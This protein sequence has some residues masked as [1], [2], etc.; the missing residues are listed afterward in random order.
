MGPNFTPPTD[1]RVG[2]A[3]DEE[4]C[5]ESIAYCLQAQAGPVS[6]PEVNPLTRTREMLC[7]LHQTENRIPCLIIRML[8]GQNLQTPLGHHIPDIFECQSGTIL[9]IAIISLL[10]HENFSSEVTHM[11]WTI[12]ST[13]K[14]INFQLSLRSSQRLRKGPGLEQEHLTWL[15]SGG[16]VIKHNK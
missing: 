5:R 14:R 7:C 6:P 10:K 8:N 1:A 12:S 3:R 11:D 15:G 13:K 4:S 9:A 2:N 16:N